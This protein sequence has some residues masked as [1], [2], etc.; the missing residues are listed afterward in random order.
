MRGLRYQGLTGTLLIVLVTY[1]VVEGGHNEVGEDVE[2]QGV[3]EEVE[4]GKTKAKSINLQSSQVTT[5]ELL[6]SSA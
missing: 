6:Y 5:R 2:H 3:L 4:A 1:L